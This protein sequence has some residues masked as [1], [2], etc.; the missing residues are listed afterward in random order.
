[1][2]S[3]R[4][5]HSLRGSR[6]LC[7]VAGIAT[8]AATALL[9]IGSAH[10]E[11]YAVCIGVNQ[12]TQLR[13]GA[14]LRGCDADATLF[15]DALRAC[16]FSKGNI[17]ILMDGAAKKKDILDAITA[18]KSH[19]RA[20]DRAVF[21]FA[22]HGTLSSRGASVI[23]PS[24]AR[25]DSEENDISVEDLY[26]AVKAVG[27]DDIQKTVVLDSCHSGGMVRSIAGLRRFKGRTP[28]FY[29]RS[30]DLNKPASHAG[31]RDVKRWQEVPVNGSDDLHTVVND[32]DKEARASGI[33]YFAAAQKDEVA[34]ETEINGTPHGLFTYYLASTLTAQGN[35]WR[36]VSASVA[37][38]VGEMTDHEQ[39][40]LLF[41][42][43][44]LDSVVFGGHAAPKPKPFDLADIYALSNPNSDAVVLERHPEYSPVAV[45]SRNNFF[46][47]HVGQDGYLVVLNKDPNDELEVVFPK[48][49]NEGAMEVHKG[50]VIRLPNRGFM[51]PDTPG[52]DGLKAILFTHV[53]AANAMLKPFGSAD[54]GF[55][56]LKVKQAKQAWKGRAWHEVNDGDSDTDTFFTSEVATLII[57]K[58][59]MGH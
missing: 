6:T 29:V 48:A 13:P 21:Y 43:T 11:D 40:P 8:T 35:L 32:T 33:C 51:S 19:L 59:G 54:R 17:H 7:T 50:Q 27:G 20:G 37:D 53:G 18:M 4:L 57:D 15:A 25:D 58:E 45:G 49:G 3:S 22:G 12:Y 24:D 36:D 2:F 52:T 55:T 14:N 46:E 26:D 9:G 44:Y 39:K 38:K 42:A 5:C 1:M 10:A 47:I 28:R 56:R 41:P 34:N 31:G 30:R 23:L 16:G